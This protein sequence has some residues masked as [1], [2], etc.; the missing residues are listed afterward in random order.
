MVT[1][2]NKAFWR[3]SSENGLGLLDEVGF[4]SLLSGC[5]L[6]P[7]EM[8]WLLCAMDREWRGM[9][10]FDDLLTAITAFYSIEGATNSSITH[11]DQVH[12]QAHYQWKMSGT[13]LSDRDTLVWIFRQIVTTLQSVG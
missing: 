13:T 2:L 12:L 7:Q 6:T 9:I 4:A 8:K 3:V 11:K 5:S 1:Q 10:S